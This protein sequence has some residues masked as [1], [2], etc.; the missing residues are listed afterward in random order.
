MRKLIGPLF[1]AFFLAGLGVARADNP[2]VIFTGNPTNGNC[3]KAIDRFHIQSVSAPCGTT[4]PGGTA[5][6]VQY[7]NAGAFGGFTINATVKS[8]LANPPNALGGVL[9]FGF[10][11]QANTFTQNQTV[12]GADLIAGSSTNDI[13]VYLYDDG[14]NGGAIEAHNAANS[15]KKTLRLNPYGGSVRTQY[16][17]LDDGFGNATAHGISASVSSGANSPSNLWTFINTDAYAAGSGNF[18][19]PFTIQNVMQ[20]GGTGQRVAF[21]V[22]EITG[23]GGAAQFYVGQQVNAVACGTQNTGQFCAGQG[24]GGGGYFSA[25]N[26]YV[27]VYSGVANG[28]EAVGEEIDTDVRDTTGN[29]NRRVGLQIVSVSTDVGHSSS[30]DTGLLFAIQSGGVGY[31]NAIEFGSGSVP[32]TGNFIYAD[33]GAFTLTETGVETVRRLGSSGDAMVVQSGY[34]AADDNGGQLHLMNVSGT[35]GGKYLDIDSGN[36]FR[37]LNEAGNSVLISVSDAGAFA[38]PHIPASCSGQPTGTIW[39]NSGVAN[40][41]P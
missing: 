7:N 32:A 30:I 38:I 33:S 18:A 3:V 16:N 34:G 40:V 13:Y 23:Y 6:Q 31:N 4:G 11:S 28:T 20:S 14:T 5:G 19:D 36:H 15:V 8:D 9:D 41:C 35:S 29:V 37:L 39:N 24:G 21:Y 25:T 22:N 12:N 10:L 26:P 2:G 27:L 17:V 1:V